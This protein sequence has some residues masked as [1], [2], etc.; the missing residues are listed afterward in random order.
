MERQKVPEG[1]SWSFWGRGEEELV[2]EG[3]WR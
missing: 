1:E 2:Q 3:A